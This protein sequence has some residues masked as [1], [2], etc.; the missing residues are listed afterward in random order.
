MLQILRFELHKI[1]RR[2]RTYISFA[3]VAAIAGIIQVA[4]LV[5]GSSFVDFAIQ[6]LSEGFALEGNILNGYFVTYII[7]QSLLVH[8]PLLVALVSGDSLAGEAAGG[9][10][11]LLLTKPHSR[12]TIV[13]AKFIAGALYALMLLFWLALVGL[14]LSVLLFGTSD[15]INLRSQE[16]VVLLENDIL[17]RYVLAFLF[18]ALAMTCVAS[19]ALL[20][21]AFAD[22]SIGPIVGTTGI[23]IFFTIVSNL[24]LPFFERFVKPWLFTT[25][26]I[27]WKGFFNDPVPYG[28]I[29]TSVVVLLLYTLGFVGA[30]V[31]YFRR[32]DIQS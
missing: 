28:E 15:M 6:G 7:L 1:L 24:G 17:W 13:V 10:L 20:L 22:N 32:K 9:T 3:I 4:L 21:S 14:G 23:V 2:P 30:T 29:R 11:R 8:V 5:D 31:L 26:M 18:A 27:G 16:V 25:H 12:G 19:L